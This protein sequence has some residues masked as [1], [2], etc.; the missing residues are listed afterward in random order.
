MPKDRR[1]VLFLASDAL[2]VVTRSSTHPVEYAIVLLVE[3]DGQWHTVRTFD[4]AHA[5]EEHH[6]HRYSGSE[7]Q[8]PEITYGPVNEAMSA[9]EIKLFGSWGD[10]VSSWE[11]TR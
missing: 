2:V 4:N 1:R 3:R 5:T 6:E 11:S 10:I 8:A 7:K 9:T